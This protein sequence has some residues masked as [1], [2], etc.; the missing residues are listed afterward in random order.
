MVSCNNNGSLRDSFSRIMRKLR[1]SLTDRCNLRCMYCMEDNPQW[2]PR[3]EILTLEEITAVASIFVKD[4]GITS[5]RLTGGEPLL[6]KDIVKLVKQL[7]SLKEYGLKRLSLST[8]GLLLK[9]F[10][11]ELVKGGIR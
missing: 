3:E 10:I 5:I 7:N 6:R 8:N 4:F 2:L 9:K 1:I 11:Q